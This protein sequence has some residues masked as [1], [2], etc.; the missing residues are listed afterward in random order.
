MPCP[1]PKGSQEAKEFMAHL[2]ARRGKG[3]C[4]GK[5]KKGGQVENP[6]KKL[7]E[8]IEERRKKYPHLFRPQGIQIRSPLEEQIRKLGI[9]GANHKEIYEELRR[10][11]EKRKKE[12][13]DKEEEIGSEW[14]RQQEIRKAETRNPEIM[15]EWWEKYKRGDSWLKPH[16]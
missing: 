13:R 11:K 1:Y 10:L 3:V 7:F 6:L 16:A 9:P 8:Q 4:G 2:R 14:R 12:K 5:R 15:R